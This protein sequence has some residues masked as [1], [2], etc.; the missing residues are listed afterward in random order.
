MFVVGNLKAA[1]AL[2]GKGSAITLVSAGGATVAGSHATGL[3]LGLTLA[4]LGPAA[5]V[6]ALGAAGLGVFFYAR[7]PDQDDC[8]GCEKCGP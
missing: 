1:G 7:P 8:G 2:A 5:L 4:S 6:I 3:G